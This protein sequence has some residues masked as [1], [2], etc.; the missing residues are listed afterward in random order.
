[1]SQDAK[2]HV[3]IIGAGP[4]GLTAAYELLK[5]PDAYRV[6][7]LEADTR[8]GGISKTVRHAGN[9]MD[10]GGHRF[11]SKDERVTAWWQQILPTQGAPAL[12]ERLLNKTAHL[13]PGGPDP[14]TEDRVMLNRQR[15]SRIYFGGNFYDYP[16]SL[17]WSTI[18]NMGLLT[19]IRAGLSY[20]MACVRKLPE[21][22]LENFYINRFG[23]VLYGMFFESY[24]EK[25]WGRHPRNIS[26]DWGAQRVKGLSLL[27]L[28]KN[29]LQR[30]LPEGRRTVETSLIESFSYPKF[31]PGQLWETVCDEVVARGGTVLTQKQVTGFACD[32][33]R[34]TAV[35]C[36]EESFACDLVLSTMPLRALIAGLPNAP[37]EARRVANGLPYRDF[38]TVGLLVNRLN[39]KNTTG[40]PTL[41]DI[42]P[43]CWIY[44]QDA[45]VLL[46]RIQIFNNWSPY[47]V[48]DPV[49]TVWIGL[50][51]FCAESDSF[52]SLSEADCV[53]LAV[54]ELI[55]IG[56]IG[57]DTPVLDSCRE[58]VEKAYPAYFD[59]YDEIDT[60]K[61]YLDT[62]DNL[63]CLGRNGQHRYNNMDHSMATA[64]EAVEN[65]VS[66]VNRRDN[67]WSVNTEQSYHEKKS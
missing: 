57:A 9:R 16:I 11:F 51:Y 35:R 30:L 19:T 34:I 17:K 38:V 22:S 6:T 45:G 29:I 24:T 54:K 28:L 64:F 48:Q 26:A 4:A 15:V 5:Q 67:V 36:G 13:V 8:F 56:V 42:V 60:V 55:Q 31:G 7:I 62:I 18:R 59:T 65:I 46:G 47:M 14:E 39:L 27:A 53:A 61:S 63:Y 12:D 52:W 40:M 33:N 23:R 2:T 25:V 3:V 20:L 41:G 58:R 37:E 66:G 43:D 1:M 10:I 32:G 44:V 21:T 50:E 49:N